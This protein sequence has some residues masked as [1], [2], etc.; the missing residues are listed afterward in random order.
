MGTMLA[1]DTCENLNNAMPATVVVFV[2][3]LLMVG[4][5]LWTVVR[6]PSSLRRMIAA[7][8]VI[9]SVASVLLI[10]G[11]MTLGNL[12]CPSPVVTLSRAHDGVDYAKCEEA[13]R[14]RAVAGGVTF[15]VALGALSA[16][17]LF[18][19]GS[20]AIPDAATRAVGASPD[21]A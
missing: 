17:G 6:S 20:D 18:M 5:A 1:C 7:I 19:R 11:S 10:R 21:G 3:G 9:A 4:L 15:I 16:A 2:T 14:R 12:R 8:A 13:A